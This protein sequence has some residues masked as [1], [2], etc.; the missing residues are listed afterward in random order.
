M[1]VCLSVIIFPSNYDV[2]RGPYKYLHGSGVLVRLTYNPH[3]SACRRLG[4]PSLRVIYLGLF[5]SLE[6][7]QYVSCPCYY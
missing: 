2:H 6:M 5:D 1:F 3:D 4:E 7:L